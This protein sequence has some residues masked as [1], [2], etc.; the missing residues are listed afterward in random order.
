MRIPFA[1]R[2]VL[3]HVMGWTL[4]TMSVTASGCFH[5]SSRSGQ[6][7]YDRPF[8]LGQVTDSI[9]ET[10]ETNAEAADFIF[11]DHE[12]RGDTAELGPGAKRHLESVALRMEHVPFPIVIEQSMFDAKPKL[13]QVRRKKIVEELARLGVPD[14]AGR[15]VVAPAFAE[16]VTAIEAESAYS[17][18]ISGSS[19][20][21]GSSRGGGG[22]YR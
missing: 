13:D 22:T 2:K 7:P 9:W 3:S 10:Q 19:S 16:G 5:H 1:P 12:F 11:Y 14:S 18:V 17:S 15:V 8:P 4:L 6:P 21:R 20:G